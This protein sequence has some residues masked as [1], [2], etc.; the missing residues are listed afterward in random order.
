ME[1]KRKR[2]FSK[3]FKE[4]VLNMLRTG[5]K[6][7]SE[8]SKDLGISESIIYRWYKKYVG[9]PEEVEKVEDKE[10]ELWELRKRLADVTEERDILKKAVSIF[11][12]QG[13]LK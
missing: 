9:T 10:K 3:E 13:N 7:V 8:L 12:K 11:S 4:D 6:K 1:L 2:K 5:D